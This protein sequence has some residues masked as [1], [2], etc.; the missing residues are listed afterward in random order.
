VGRA[1][2]AGVDRGVHDAS[3]AQAGVV[4]G[5]ALQRF[6]GEHV[7]ALLADRGAAA[8]WRRGEAG[9]GEGHL[10]VRVQL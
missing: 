10:A 8:A 3:G 2:L 5:Q 7:A 1:E 9:D 6:A 4:C